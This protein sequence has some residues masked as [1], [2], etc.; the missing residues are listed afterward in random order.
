MGTFNEREKK[1]GF[2]GKIKRYL[3]TPTQTPNI[4]IKR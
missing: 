2:G 1:L 3:R 4:P